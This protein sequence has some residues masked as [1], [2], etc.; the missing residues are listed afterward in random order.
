MGS[1]RITRASNVEPDEHGR[2]WADI[3]PMG[4]PVLGPYIRR[5]EAFHAEYDFF[6]TRAKRT[7][8][9]ARHCYRQVDKTTGLRSD[10]TIVLCGLK[11]SE[12]YPDPLR[13]VSYYAADIDKH[14]VFLT[15]NFTLPA[16]TIAKLYR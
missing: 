14:F 1:L 15:N 6:V 7:L 11:S 5:S 2:W 13:R 12:L 3:S 8:D 4:G 9:Y 10:S 16:L